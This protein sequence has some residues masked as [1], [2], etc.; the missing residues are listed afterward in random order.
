MSMNDIAPN[1]SDIEDEEAAELAALTAAVE[2]AR[3]NPRSMPHSE[4]RA[5]FADSLATF[6]KRG[7]VS[8]TRELVAGQGVIIVSVWHG[9]QDR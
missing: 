9:A 2:K 6:P 4:V 1:L 7:R 3:A 8:G 5:W